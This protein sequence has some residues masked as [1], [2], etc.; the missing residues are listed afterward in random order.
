MVVSDGRAKKGEH[1]R[2]RILRAA[3][4][5]LGEVGVDGFSASALAKRAGISK[6]TI[7]HHFQN[8]DEVPL[9]V[10]ET[11]LSQE[12]L[13]SLQIH[14]SFPVYLEHFGGITLATAREQ[15]MFLRVYITF[16]A[17][18]LHDE[19]YRQRIKARISETHVRMCAALG[20]RLDGHLAASEVQAITDLTQATLDGLVLRYL[21]DA[22]EQVFTRAWSLL[23]QLLV[24]RYGRKTRV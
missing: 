20:E 2:N 21:L 1:T 8:L 7:F 11:L 4:E 12:L 5:L 13:D 3:A 17:R 14:T 6:G 18:A 23:V 16:F 10:L 19:R 9:E 15:G 22:D 24:S